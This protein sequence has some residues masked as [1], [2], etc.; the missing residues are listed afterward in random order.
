LLAAA[1][2]NAMAEDSRMLDHLLEVQ[3]ILTRNKDHKRLA[4]LHPLTD[5][6]GNTTA[7][8]EA[9]ATAVW[10][11][12]A[13]RVVRKIRGVKVSFYRRFEGSDVYT[14]DC[15]VKG[16]RVRLR[17]DATTVKEAEGI[18]VMEIQK[19]QEASNGVTA[20]RDV[21]ARGRQG[22]ATGEQVLARLLGGDKVAEVR[23]LR[24]YGS[25]LLR[26]L[27]IANPTNPR[28]VKLDVGLS[29]SNLEKFFSK[30]QGRAEGVNWKDYLPMNGGLMSTIRN[31]RA[32]FN[33]EMIE[34]KFGD[35]VM[36]DLTPLRKLK[37]LKVSVEKFKPWPKEVYETMHAF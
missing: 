37:N 33:D 27:R 29:Q 6:M 11:Y 22:V 20:A 34:E 31:L 8:M 9:G 16:R 3:R 30:G 13:K 18:A 36:P 17:L 2:P 32:L 14:M 12:W 21:K 10:D 26:V 24:T 7:T 15:K 23:T 25:S 5:T 1:R 28:A 35:L 19:L 4:L